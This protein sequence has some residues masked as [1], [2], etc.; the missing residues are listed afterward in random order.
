VGNDWKWLSLERF[1]GAGNRR[2]AIAD[3]KKL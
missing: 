3:F 2:A 1:S